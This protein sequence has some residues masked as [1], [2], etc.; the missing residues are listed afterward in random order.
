MLTTVPRLNPFFTRENQMI[1]RSSYPNFEMRIP[2]SQSF[3][4][5][6]NN[7]VLALGL[8]KL[9]T[10]QQAPWLAV[11]VFQPAFRVDSDGAALVLLLENSAWL[12]LAFD[13]WKRKKKLCSFKADVRM[14]AGRLTF[15]S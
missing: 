10:N 7:H 11:K 13:L 5:K 6:H 14:M 8:I 1:L 4:R 15:C 3:R 12:A 2:S 9:I